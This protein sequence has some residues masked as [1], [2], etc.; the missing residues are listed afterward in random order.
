MS[1]DTKTASTALDVRVPKG[2]LAAINALVEES[3]LALAQGGQFDRAFT[4]AAAI[5]Q[6]GK[7]ITS[8]MM[9][10]IMQLQGK[11]LG[12]RTDRDD[13]GGYDQPTVKGCL[14]EA[15]LH[16]ARPVGNE[17]NIISARPYFTKEY[18]VR[19]VKEFEGIDELHTTPGEVEVKGGNAH[20]DYVAAWTLDGKPMRLEKIRRKL[21]SGQTFDDRIVV[22]V[23]TGMGYDAILGKARR[24]MYR[25]ILEVVTER[26][27]QGIPVPTDGD[28]DDA[29]DVASSPAAPKQS[30]LFADDPA[31]TETQI[32]DQAP[33]IA[34]YEQKLGECKRSSDV[35]RVAKQAGGDQRL[36]TETRKGI[37]DACTETTKKLAG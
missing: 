23:N 22:R 10:D 17:W 34:E 26:K 12:F 9:E 15:T 32:K 13:K 16:G 30:S 36:T 11:S 4:M 28:V 20:V 14:I 2:E 31:Q 19:R 7:L 29:L 37:M 35:G 25:E 24:R 18:F 21:P 27:S 6:I 8:P 1:T 33:F 3:Q 5:R